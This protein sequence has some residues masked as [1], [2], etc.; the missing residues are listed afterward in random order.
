MGN[1]WY[2]E[3]KIRTNF[4]SYTGSYSKKKIV[5][6]QKMYLDYSESKKRYEYEPNYNEF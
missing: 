4:D 5:H 2:D 6:S 1:I 3:E